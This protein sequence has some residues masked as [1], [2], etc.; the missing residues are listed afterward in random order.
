MRRNK[1]S[2]DNHGFSL[3]EILIAMVILAIIVVPLLHTFVSSARAN[4]QAKQTLRMTTA[5]QDI[6]EG[7]KAYTIEELAYQFNYPDASHAT[8]PLIDVD[9]EF[10]IIK[11]ELIN[12]TAR[13]LKYDG[14]TYTDVIKGEA[15]P[16]KNLVTASIFSDNHGE[17]YEFLGARDAAG[18]DIGKYY[19]EMTQVSLQDDKTMRFDALVELDATKYRAGGG[20]TPELN[21]KEVVG[22]RTMNNLYDA[23]YVATENDVH[24]AIQN[25]NVSLSPTSEITEPDIQRTITIDV[26]QTTVAGKNVTKAKVHIKYVAKGKGIG[27]TDLEYEPMSA[28]GKQ[29]FSNT[30]EDMELR[31]VYL[32]YYPIYNAEANKDQIIFNNNNA[33]DLQFHIT[34]QEPSAADSSLI[35]KEAGYRCDVRIKDAGIGSA[36]DSATKIQTN[37]T[38]NLYNVYAPESAP[39]SASPNI[40]YYFNGAADLI[41]ALNVK[42]LAGSEVKD[43]IFDVTVK[44]Y[45]AGAALNGFPEDERLV[46]LTGTKDN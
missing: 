42:N 16:D 38:T 36:A 34:K 21:A 5:A 31:N 32:F 33:V 39:Y 35:I 2:A 4:M 29:I 8:N 45:E 7:L 46:T 40:R 11:K 12:G 1:L 15:Q 6:M 44:I 24:N 27:G 41:G 26:D 22:I 19:F 3:V 20:A 9:N 30:T 23:F 14:T 18:N 28:S 10:H 43:R 17:T 37:L 13:E 25:M